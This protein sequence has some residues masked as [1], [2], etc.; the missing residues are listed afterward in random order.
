MSIMVRHHKGFGHGLNP[1]TNEDINCESCKREKTAG[2]E[3]SITDGSAL[4]PAPLPWQQDWQRLADA[5]LDHDKGLA[6]VEL[7]RIGI[8]HHG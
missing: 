7:D 8:E 1:G 6:D 2:Q 3:P 4:P 5:E